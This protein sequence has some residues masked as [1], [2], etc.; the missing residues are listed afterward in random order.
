MGIEPLYL[1]KKNVDK[2]PLLPSGQKRYRDTKLTG[3]GLRVGKSVKSYY[4]EK[5]INGK[6]VRVTLGNHGQITA[7]QAR[8]MATEALGTMTQGINPLDVKK[9]KKAESVTLKEAYL[10]Y[11]EARKNLKPKTI[12]DYDRVME[13]AF[14]A[15]QKRPLNKITKDMVAKHYAKLGK[16]RG[17]AYANLAMRLLRAVFNFA[18]WQYED[19]QGKPILSDNPVSRLS[20]TKG[21]FKIKRRDSAINS[22]QLKKWYE[23]A[24]ALPNPNHKNYLIFIL[25]TGVRR[26]EAARLKWEDVN[27]KQ[28]TMTL[29]DTKNNEDAVLPLSNFALS[30]V[31]EQKEH[32]TNEYVFSGTGSEGYIVEPK[33]AVKFVTDKSGVPF[34]IHDLRRTFITAASGLVTAYEL[35]RLVNHKMSGDVTAGYI[36]SNVEQLRAGANK[37]ANYFLKHIN[38]NKEKGKVIPFP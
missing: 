33:G 31:K 11:K 23:A 17:K 26:Q 29:R 21:W 12:Y 5:R 16:S 6:S 25:F 24:Q 22:T 9:T 19:S 18:I 8:K 20:Q 36:V 37:I 15:W 7:E 32:S 14:E 2:L 27:L 1:T 13:V 30:V 10:K 34:M 28:K 3:F 4:V 35:K 38:K